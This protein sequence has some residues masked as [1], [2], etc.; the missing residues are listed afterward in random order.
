MDELILALADQNDRIA[1]DAQRLAEQDA[2]IKSQA[3]ENKKRAAEI[4]E[5]AAELA[6]LKEGLAMM[7]AA[8]QSL[9]TAAGGSNKR[10]R[11]DSIIVPGE[12][13]RRIRHSEAPQSPA[14][15]TPQQEVSRK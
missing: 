13:L 7:N 6:Q 15:C 11:T 12:A 4:K 2:T 9:G 5:Q 8:V 10:P 3:A 14:T 1:R